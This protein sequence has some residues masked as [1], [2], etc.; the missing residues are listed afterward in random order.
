MKNK[1]LREAGVIAAFLL[2]M[3]PV[4][5]GCSQ[6]EAKTSASD[7]DVP[8]QGTRPDKVSAEERESLSV[9]IEPDSPGVADSLQG[10]IQNGASV[11][12]WIWYRNDQELSEATTL[13]LPSHSAA[14]GDVVTLVVKGNGQEVSA[15]VEI[16]NSP[17]E[18]V[19]VNL[20]SNEIFRGRDIVALPEGADPDGDG[21]EFRYEWRINGDPVAFQSEGTLPGDAFRKGDE[22]SLLVT[23]YDGQDEGPVF[24]PEPFVVPNGAP[25]FSSRP[26]ER[27]ESMEYSYQAL[28]EDPDGDPLLYVLEEGPEGMMMDQKSG[29]LT[30]DLSGKPIGDFPVTISVTDDGGLWARQTFT[31]QMSP[32]ER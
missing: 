4:L 18:V 32:T 8:V 16:V 30:W 5:T 12:E 15:T 17:P 24:T 19:N 21:V 29:L 13:V 23:P 11:Q 26:P 6:D 28:A 27:F 31:I 3:I 9:F 2:T 14:K 22:I 7:P 25:R 10:R 20:E 1:Y